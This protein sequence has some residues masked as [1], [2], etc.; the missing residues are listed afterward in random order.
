MC[1]SIHLKIGIPQT[2]RTLH[3]NSQKVHKAKSDFWLMFRRLL[4]CLWAICIWVWQQSWRIL[5]RDT[6]AKLVWELRQQVIIHSVLHRAQ[7]NDRPRVVHWT[8]WETQERLCEYKM[9]VKR[10]NS[11]NMKDQWLSSQPQ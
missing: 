8:G 6:R 9:E 11:N 3:P 10:N 1:S 7:N 2:S 5:T 4:S